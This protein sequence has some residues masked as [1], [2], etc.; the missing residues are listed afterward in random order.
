MKTDINN[1]L[2][3]KL[4]ILHQ[5]LAV[6]SAEEVLSNP[7]FNQ[8]LEGKFKNATI[9]K[10]VEDLISLS[11]NQSNYYIK[12]LREIRDHLLGS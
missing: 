3:L 7:K 2:E 12:L 5:L 8:L 9:R 10:S 1:D 4:E 11:N 6:K